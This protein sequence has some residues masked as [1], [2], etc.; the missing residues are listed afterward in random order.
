MVKPIT[1]RVYGCLIGGAIGDALGAPAEGLSYEQVR[2]RYGRLEEFEPYSHPFSDGEPGSVT[3]D[4]TLRQYIAFAIAKHE[5]R[6]TAD[7]YANVLRTRLSLE[8]TWV[9]EE[10]TLKKLLAGVDPRR[11]GRG[12]IPTAT[13]TAAITPIGVVNACDPQT[14]YNDAFLVASVHHDGLERASAATVAAGVAEALSPDASLEDVLDTLY[15]HAPDVLRR[16]FELS[17]ELADENDSMVAFTQRFYDELLDWRW[18]PVEWDRDRYHAGE[19]ISGRSIE[20]LP[21]VVGILS[22]C[23]D[24]P[25]RTLVEA[26]GFGRDSD[27]IAS[28][29]GGFVGALYGASALRSEWINQ[30]ED[31]NTDL[32]A[33]L[34]GDPDADFRSMAERLVDALAAEIERKRSHVATVENLL[35]QEV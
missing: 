30:C 1:D 33:E 20:I 14:A 31:A 18:P 7:E 19:L 28:L 26:V 4:S 27:T 10:I 2:D 12:N 24:D 11:T 9:P 32:F 16:G 3:D 23:G 35:D 6:I 29:A 5:G 21:A 15:S 17:L 13:L 22:I 34:E 8:R 25:N